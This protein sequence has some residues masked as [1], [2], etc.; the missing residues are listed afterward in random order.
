M[1][2]IWAHFD[3]T[4]TEHIFKCS[5]CQKIVAFGKP[6]SGSEPTATP[7]SWPENI[8]DYVGSCQ[9][10]KTL[11]ERVSLIEARLAAANIP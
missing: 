2:H 3:T 10:D 4:T 8:D 7:S 5:V 9:S 1:A 11:D 6:G